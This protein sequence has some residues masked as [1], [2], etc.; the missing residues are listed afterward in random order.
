ME[1]EKN[2]NSDTIVDSCSEKR[3]YA[4]LTDELKRKFIRKIVI[5]NLSIKQASEL[6]RINYSSAKAI[7]SS[8]RKECFKKKRG[9]TNKSS[10]I[11]SYIPL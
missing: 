2:L 5:D 9:A 3:K 4:K 7:I 10:T 11:C 6:L 1:L 8:H